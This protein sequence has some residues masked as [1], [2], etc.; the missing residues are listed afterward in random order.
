M[1]MHDYNILWVHCGEKHFQVRQDKEFIC[2]VSVYE[3]ESNGNEKHIHTFNDPQTAIS[4]AKKL[5][6]PH[7]LETA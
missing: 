7:M 1:T 4:F 6:K 5:S 3:I 2:M